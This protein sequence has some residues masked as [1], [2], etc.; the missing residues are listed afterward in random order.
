[1]DLERP[2]DTTFDVALS[3]AGEDRPAAEA[4]AEACKARGLTV[5]YDL[6][7]RATLWGKDLYQHLANV[8]SNNARFCVVF[9]SEHHVRKLWTKHELKAAQSRAFRAP[10]EYILPI[11]LDGTTLPGLPETVGY[12]EWSS[13]SPAEVA[14]LLATKLGVER[15]PSPPVTQ[16]ERASKL[17]DS[18]P[19]R[20][21]MQGRRPDVVDL[22]VGEVWWSAG[23]DEADALMALLFRSNRAGV[24]IGGSPVTLG[25]IRRDRAT[26]VWATMKDPGGAAEATGRALTPYDAREQ[27]LES[28][29]GL[30][31]RIRDLVVDRRP[32]WRARN[33]DLLEG[34]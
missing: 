28:L 20:V 27:V 7:E 22:Y 21:R 18:K 24:P 4:L 8:Y 14:E 9:V 17:D 23:I 2:S 16:R 31:P 10:Q 26:W 15:K 5:F 33:K 34:A 11:R 6:Y 13:T 3:F 25:S 29:N 1:M 12:L 32:S 30:I 19:R